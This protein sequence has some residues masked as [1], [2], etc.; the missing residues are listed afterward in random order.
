MTE[1][2]GSPAYRAVTPCGREVLSAIEREVARCGGVATL[3]HDTIEWMCSIGHS[4]CCFAQ[5]QIRL[6]GFVDVEFAYNGLRPTHS[7]RMSTRWQSIGTAEA[8]R[9]AGLARKPKPAVRQP[10]AALGPLLLVD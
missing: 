8:K 10:V 6:L 7:F 3:S 5:R 4:N 9:L 2:D 1:R